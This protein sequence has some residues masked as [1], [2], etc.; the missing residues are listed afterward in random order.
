MD[1]R[2]QK[3]TE[4]A[5]LTE[6]RLNQDFIDWLNK[7]G[8]RILTLVLIVLVIY[9]AN[10]WWKGKQVE[11]RDEA[12]FQ[13]EQARISGSPDA[14]LAVARDHDGRGAVAELATIEAAD[15]LL[16]AARRGVTP[17]GSVLNPEDALDEE[18]RSDLYRRAADLYEQAYRATRSDSGRPVQRIAARWG[19]A[20]T[21]ISLR[22]WDGAR[23]ALEDVARFADDA[24][25]HRLATVARDRLENFD[26][27]RDAPPLLPEEE[28]ATVTPRDPGT[29]GPAPSP[30]VNPEADDEERPGMNL[31]MPPSPLI[32]DEELT[33]APAE[34]LEQP[35]ETAPATEPP[36]QGEAS[37]AGE[38]GTTPPPDLP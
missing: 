18:G 29:F 27:L 19:M 24:G 25:L 10:D 33:P 35:V 22:E 20:A 21:A 5:G 1:Q 13:L 32:S 28:I 14:L 36:A 23:A 15:I 7:W 26:D 2:Q 34:E 8:P 17:G 37:G 38:G 3:I 9:V 31:L 16:A 12:F 6:S 30:L 11:S 4:G